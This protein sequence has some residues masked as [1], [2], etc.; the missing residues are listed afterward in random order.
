MPQ[1]VRSSSHDGI[2]VL[3]ISKLRELNYQRSGGQ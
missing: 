1:Q 2:A 3:E